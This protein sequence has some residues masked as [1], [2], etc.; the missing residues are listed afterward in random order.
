MLTRQTI[1]IPGLLGAILL[2]VWAFGFIVLGVHGTV[3]H[4]LVPISGLLMISQGIRR[5]NREED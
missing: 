5:L 4:L 3:Y 1:G 2:L